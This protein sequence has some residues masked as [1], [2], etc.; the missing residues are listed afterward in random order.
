M[1]GQHGRVL[2]ITYYWPPSGGAGVQRW[3]KF[4]KYLR[5]YGWEPVIYTP[6]NPEAPS[7]DQSLI[8]DIPAGIEIIRRPILEPYTLYKRL[9]GM[10]PK[11]KINAGFLHE[12]G[13]QGMAQAA[14]V[15][16]RGNLFIPDARVAW[17]RPSVRFL[18][19]YLRN[20]PVDLIAS[21]G[22]PHSMHLIANKL[23][24]TIGIPWV[25]DF[26]DPWTE[27]D[28]YSELKLTRLADRIHHRLERKVLSTASA[29]VV[30]S[31]GMEQRFQQIVPRKYEVITNGFDESDFDPPPRQPAEGIF[32]ISHI[33][34]IAPARNP[35][36][37][38]KALSALCRSNEAFRKE[39]R[40][41]FTG[42]VDHSVLKDLE[43]YG[44]MAHYHKMGY[45]P[46]NQV[47]AE[48]QQSNLLLLLINRSANASGILTG[49]IFE[50]LA[51]G[52]PILC[53]GPTTGDAAHILRETGSGITVGFDDEL[54]MKQALE[55][56]LSHEA[57]STQA[58]P[59]QVAR[60]SRRN[61]TAEM[62]QV[63]NRAVSGNS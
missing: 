52:R 57:A 50:Y 31:R 29:V 36:A 51:S 22:P 37:L 5:E 23:H 40:L 4:A 30:V 25:A 41:Q 33:G 34:S 24:K 11:E 58:N 17:I 35:E 44:L 38:W 1:P 54:G 62:A 20:H 27:I 59:A 47:M 43:K 9:L 10:K 53:V 46:H 39:L 12:E 48:M 32:C 49:K 26:R 13:K 55:Q 15:W 8:N 16:L 21:T 28:F 63:F 7:Q 42:K 19:K 18:K 2:I 6:S 3:L 60:Y 61:L 14:S 45:K 56:F